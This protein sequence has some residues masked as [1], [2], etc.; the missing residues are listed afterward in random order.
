V[1]FD[2][3]GTSISYLD[4]PSLGYASSARSLMKIAK[5]LDGARSLPA[6]ID[7]IEAFKA[8]HM[9]A[10]QLRQAADSRG[11]KRK[12]G[13]LKSTYFGLREFLVA[14]NKGLVHEMIRRSSVS[15]IE[16][17]DLLSE[18]LMA[19][20][21][22]VGSFDPWAGVRFSTYAC[23]SIARGL[24]ALSAQRSRY[25]EIL[26]EAMDKSRERQMREENVDHRHEHPMM[27]DLAAI[28][29]E[30]KASLSPMER[31]VISRR[32][33][34]SGRHKDSTLSAIGK[35]LA[36]SKERVRQIQTNALEKIR[37]FLEATPVAAGLAHA[38]QSGPVTELFGST[39]MP[40]DG[41]PA[42]KKP[43]AA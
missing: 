8:F 27:H 37:S 18:G 2:F 42:H 3:E 32:I 10:F 26:H 1:S 30:N 19:L 6:D 20:F 4:H 28:I 35:T 23:T 31:W 40:P 34:R 12:A 21:R 13:A 33:Y 15:G 7:Q 38:G 5:G 41:D 25:R 17:D 39:F 43:R 29:R 36:L 14:S 9:V 22:S 11:G 24:H 16:Y